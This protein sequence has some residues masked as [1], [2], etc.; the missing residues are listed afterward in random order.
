[1]CAACLAA[2]CCADQRLPIP[3]DP[4]RGV[5]TGNLGPGVVPARLDLV[6]TLADRAIEVTA[7]RGMYE[8]ELR[9]ARTTAAT[10]TTARNQ[11]IADQ[12]AQLRHH[13]PRGPRLRGHAKPLQAVVQLVDNI[14]KH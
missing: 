3:S 8:V 11:V 1:M 5:L 4:N 14:V 2:T 7:R 10:A 6:L 9:T 12:A 13:L